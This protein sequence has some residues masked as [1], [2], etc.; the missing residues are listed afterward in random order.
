MEG[1]VEVIN[2]IFISDPENV[3][4]AVAGADGMVVSDDT[5]ATA[6]VSDG[7][8]SEPNVVL[9]GDGLRVLRRRW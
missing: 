5:V 1:F 7:C 2:D 3:L 9:K 8:G 4:E 6:G